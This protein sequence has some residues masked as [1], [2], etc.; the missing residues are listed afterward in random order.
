MK[1]QKLTEDEMNLIMFTI[2]ISTLFGGVVIG[3]ILCYV[4]S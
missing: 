4:F 1:K 3:T 2:L